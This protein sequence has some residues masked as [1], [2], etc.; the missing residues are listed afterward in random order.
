MRM[1]RDH[2]KDIEKEP[3]QTF[4]D[5]KTV[6]KIRNTRMGL[7]VNYTLQEKKKRVGNEDIVIKN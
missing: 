1:V 2:M 6:S 3:N 7:K 4:R 5:G